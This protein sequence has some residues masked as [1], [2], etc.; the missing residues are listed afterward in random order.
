MTCRL[1]RYNHTGDGQV[2]TDCDCDVPHFSVFHSTYSHL[3]R[4]LG[5]T[6]NTNSH[7]PSTLGLPLTCLEFGGAGLD[8][9]EGYIMSCLMCVM[10]PGVPTGVTDT[11]PGLTLCF[12]SR[13][14][15]PSRAR[16]SLLRPLKRST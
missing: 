15:K 7:L 3:D 10:G 11:G 1:T 6:D 13:A 16:M 9:E 4:P 5:T 8:M 2:R 12:M 14:T